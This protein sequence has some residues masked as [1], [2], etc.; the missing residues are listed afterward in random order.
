MNKQ[1]KS[2]VYDLVLENKKWS[3]EQYTLLV[4]DL[5]P[6]DKKEL[7]M[8]I[9]NANGVMANDIYMELM[10]EKI[11]QSSILETLKDPDIDN[12][13]NMSDIIMDKL[14]DLYTNQMQE[15]INDALE[16]IESDSEAA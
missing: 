7:V 11:V 10:H 8:L 9:I 15:M 2:F 4:Q 13:L 3:L 12:K 6:D 5:Y 1:L 14:C 16:E